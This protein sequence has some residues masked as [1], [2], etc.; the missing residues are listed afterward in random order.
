MLSHLSV[1]HSPAIESQSTFAMNPVTFWTYDETSKQAHC[2]RGRTFG[3]PG[4]ARCY[5][6]G[7]YDGKCH[8]PMIEPY[9]AYRTGWWD[10]EAEHIDKQDREFEAAQGEQGASN[11]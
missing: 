7:F 1:W 8:A 2:G 9:A 5:E 10:A 6:R 11:G 4:E 3:T